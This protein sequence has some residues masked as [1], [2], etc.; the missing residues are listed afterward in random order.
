MRCAAVPGGGI[1]TPAPGDCQ[2]G[3]RAA[4]RRAAAQGAK[5]EA[6]MTE[7]IL[8]ATFGIPL[9]LVRERGRTWSIPRGGD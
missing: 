2:R 8:E 9:R 4:A 5:E 6:V 1:Y 3:R 7:P